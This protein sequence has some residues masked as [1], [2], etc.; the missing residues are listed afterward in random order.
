MNIKP[1]TEDQ[2]HQ[3]RLLA[4]QGLTLREISVRMKFCHM[5]IRAEMMKAGITTKKMG[6]KKP[7]Y[8]KDKSESQFFQWSA[9]G[10]DEYKLFIG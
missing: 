5:K 2:V 3:I 8:Q 7:T 6:K 9:Y 4:D 1:L 10:N